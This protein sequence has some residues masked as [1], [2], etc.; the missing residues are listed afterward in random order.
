MLH[1]FEDQI[2]DFVH[3]V[4]IYDWVH[5]GNEVHFFKHLANVFIDDFG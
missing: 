5:Q 2:E 1:D 4:L 3:V